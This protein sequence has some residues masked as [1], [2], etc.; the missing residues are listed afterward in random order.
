MDGE[1]QKLLPLDES[2][3]VPVKW[4]SWRKHY[5][6]YL[7]FALSS[8]ARRMYDFALYLT[9]SLAFPDTLVLPALVALVGSSSIV[10]FGPYVSKWIDIYPRWSLMSMAMVA[11]NISSGISYGLVLL[12]YR[13][14]RETREHQD[15]LPWTEPLFLGLVIPLVLLTTI[16]GVLFCYFFSNVFSLLELSAML[17]SVGL[18]K[19]WVLVIAAA[20]DP[21]VPEI[22]H[23]NAMLKVCVFLSVS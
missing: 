4:Y 23:I 2:T 5:L 14:C 6:L 22:H 16:T 1:K 9:I 20:N 17:C 10:F 12:L 21:S 13:Y 11:L 19:N 15:S 7:D 8:W 18:S 3:P